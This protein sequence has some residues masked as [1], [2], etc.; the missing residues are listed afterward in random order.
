MKIYTLMLGA[1]MFSTAIIKTA[2]GQ[3]ADTIREN[4]IELQMQIDSLKKVVGDLNYDLHEY[5]RRCRFFA[6]K[7]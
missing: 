3:T 4:I 1:M 5:E 6:A 2:T 7:V